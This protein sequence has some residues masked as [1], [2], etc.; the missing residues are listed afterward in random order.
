M[1]RTC[2]LLFALAVSGA[3][4]SLP[5]QEICG[6]NWSL[7]E[8]TR[9]GSF[10]GP[11]ALGR[12]GSVAL[13]PEGEI[14]V[15]QPMSGVVMVFDADGALIRTFGRDGSGPGDFDFGPRTVRWADGQLWVGDRSRAQSFTSDGRPDAFVSF[16]YHE[17]HEGVFFRPDAPLA[18]GSMLTRQ[19]V[20]QAPDL[21]T[22]LP[23]RRFDRDGEVI[24]T[25]ATLDVTGHRVIVN[26][27]GGFTMH[28]FWELLPGSNG[29]RLHHA[30]SADRSELVLLGAVTE[31][32]STPSFDLLRI[33]I[34]GDTLLKRSIDYDPIE[35]TRS[36]RSW[37]IGEFAAVMAG[38]YSVG[39]SRSPRMTEAQRNR[40]RRNAREWLELP[41][42]Y[43]PVRQVLAGTDGTIWVL[44]EPDLPYLVNRWEVY[45]D[46]GQLIGRI[47]DG[48][49]SDPIKPWLPKRQ[50]L[51]AN[52]ETVWVTTRDEFAVSYLHRFDVGRGCQ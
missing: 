25:I 15:P 10:D 38:D 2:V 12:F 11:D 44:R 39:D 40:E 43:P 35:L 37:W 3:V 27:A 7:T 4:V 30:V 48:W 19:S 34:A 14:Y 36:D 9:I 51:S 13:G 24:D 28:P 46:A 8:A 5:A 31:S 33:S 1:R 32:A 16:R 23:V 42:T 26:D 47:E 52:S 45:S 49:G 6:T 20:T 22:S 18:D 50:L 29:S 41:R 17:P 21:L